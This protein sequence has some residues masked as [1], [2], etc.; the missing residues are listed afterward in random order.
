MK[1]V[2]FF[3]TILC[4]VIVVSCTS[5]PVPVTSINTISL[6]TVLDVEISAS[7]GCVKSGET[8]KLRATVTNRGDK[9]QVID[10]KDKP[11][12]DI[13]ADFTQQTRHGEVRWSDGK[14]LT[15]DLIHLELAPGASKTIEMD[16][17]PDRDAYTRVGAEFNYD[18]RGNR[19][20]SAV[21]IYV[22][23]CPGFGP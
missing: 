12:L 21:T 2:F 14:P 6:N 5:A 11:V 17:I 20:G 4:S 15:S 23:A 1:Y 7:N 8:V 16:W 22:G 19:L 3:L 9:T 10:L 18:N 13:L